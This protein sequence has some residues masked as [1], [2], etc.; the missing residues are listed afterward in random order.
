MRKLSLLFLTL[1][2]ALVA[3][4]QGRQDQSAEAV[5][6]AVREVLPGVEVLV[7][8]GFECLKG[9]KIGLLTNP[10]GIDRKLRSTVDILFNAP[11]VELKVLFAPEHGVRGDVYAGSKLSD[12]VDET[13][14]LPV[15]SLYGNT[16]TPTPEML[17][18]LD[19][20]VY[21]IQDVGTRSYTFI[22]SLGLLMRACA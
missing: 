4:G 18:G 16:R 6:P 2:T 21:D 12:T 7:K 1:L 3:C 14:G 5:E 15:R 10:S 11:G 13:T 20:V 8:S 17:K 9:K 22:S 19:A